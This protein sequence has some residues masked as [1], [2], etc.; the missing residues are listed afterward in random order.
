MI[1]IFLP[2]LQMGASE[3]AVVIDGVNSI[4]LTVQYENVMIG[5]DKASEVW[6]I[7]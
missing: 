2:N 1:L 6:D 4:Q 3:K 7:L 5:S